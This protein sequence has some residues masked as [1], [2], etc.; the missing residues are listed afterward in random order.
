MTAVRV[1]ICG[2]TRPQDARAAVSAGASAIGMIFW[3]KSPRFVSMQTARTI[4]AAAESVTRVGVFVDQPVEEVGA[5]ARFVPLDALQLHGHEAVAEYRIDRPIVK[6]FALGVAWQ[7]GM[8]DG[9][10]DDVL[11][12][13]DAHDEVRKGGTGQRIDWELAAAAASS[14]RIVLAGGL[15]PENVGEAVRRVRP[16]AVDVSTGVEQSP[17]IKDEGRIYE[18]IEAVRSTAGDV[19]RRLL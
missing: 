8:L 19:P 1:K 6:A 2:I 4:A 11:P 15:N 5:I 13:L 9:L 17:G 12:L 18:L 3:P 14:R 10:P 7:I 16:Y